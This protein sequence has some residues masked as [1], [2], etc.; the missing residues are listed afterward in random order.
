MVYCKTTKQKFAG[1]MLLSVMSEHTEK[2]VFNLIKKARR[3]IRITFKK[4]SGRA[5]AAKRA[6]QE[7]DAQQ[8]DEEEAVGR[9]CRLFLC[10]TSTLEFLQQYGL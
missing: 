1:L 6:R 3:P 2:S 5:E 9:A 7:A 10:I 8:E 4:R